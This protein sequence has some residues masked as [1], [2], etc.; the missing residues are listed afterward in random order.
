M[1]TYI[2]R[3][4]ERRSRPRDIGP[5]R[6]SQS[7]RRAGRRPYCALAKGSASVDALAETQ[8]VS[9]VPG[10]DKRCAAW[11]LDVFAGQTKTEQKRKLATY[12]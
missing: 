9:A 1:R 5:A 6:S 4:S 11:S 3:A 12:P 7:P 2:A 10:N 8:A